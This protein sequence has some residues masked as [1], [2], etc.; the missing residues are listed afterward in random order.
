MSDYIKKIRTKD[1][2]K[3]IDYGSLANL[4][5]FKTIN[6]ES[7]LGNGDIKVE[8]ENGENQNV[9][10]SGYAKNTDLDKKQDKLVSGTNIKTINGESV[11]GSG[12]IKLNASSIKGLNVLC[13]GDSITAGQGM[14]AS[15]RWANVLATKLGWNLTVQA[16]GGIPLSSYYYTA[17]GETDISICKKA[18]SIADMSTKPDLVIDSAFLQI[19]MSVSPFAV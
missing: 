19:L 11:L 9:D 16:Q 3:Q 4:P 17:N 12:D 5:S 1:G 6:G 13:L 10:L 18:E 2:D 14:T 15:T 8:T 7:I